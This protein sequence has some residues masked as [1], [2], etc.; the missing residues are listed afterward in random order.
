MQAHQDEDI[1]ERKQPKNGQ[2]GSQEI[3]QTSAANTRA[4]AAPCQRISTNVRGTIR[5]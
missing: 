4:E 2:E 3:H 1:R 5:A